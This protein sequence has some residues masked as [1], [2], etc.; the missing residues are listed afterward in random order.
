MELQHNDAALDGNMLA[1]PL[2]D[3][4]TEEVTTAQARCRGCGKLSAIAEL[5]VYGPEP[6]L[7]ARCP[8]CA[9]V[10]LRLVRASGSAWLDLSG[11]SVLRLHVAEAA[12][13]A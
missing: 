6:G 5:A 8:G 13:S 1:G 4:F 9:G 3:V 12:A 2:A 10:L 11:M 7:V